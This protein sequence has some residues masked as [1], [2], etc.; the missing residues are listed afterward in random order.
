MIVKIKNWFKAK[1]T[2]FKKWTIQKIKQF[3]KSRFLLGLLML[4]IGIT[5]TIAWNEINKIDF[6]AEKI[7]VE[8]KSSD[9]GVVGTPVAHASEEEGSDEGKMIINQNTPPTTQDI[10][11]EII[12]VFKDDSKVALAIFKTESAL[13][14]KAQNWNCHYY[15]NGKKYSTACKIEDR[16]KAWSVDC[17]IAQINYITP[18][19]SKECPA[20]LFDYKNN[21]AVAKSMFD[22]RN[23]QPWVTYNEGYYLANL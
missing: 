11:N 4:I 8:A 22:R 21:I 16:Q 15:Q 20:E 17:G 2:Q 10:E 19:E 6:T 9:V 23:F 12:N 5:Y 1:K 18:N 3:M 14:P 7:V 13:N